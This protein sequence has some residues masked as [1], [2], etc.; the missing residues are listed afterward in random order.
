MALAAA[1]ATAPAA[2]HALTRGVTIRGRVEL[3]QASDRL[4][5]AVRYRDGEAVQF[6]GAKGFVDARP[7]D[8]PHI[9]EIYNLTGTGGGGERDRYAV[10]LEMSFPIL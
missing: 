8:L 2:G 10:G 5:Y 3:P 4:E 7:A 6:L 9:R 1:L